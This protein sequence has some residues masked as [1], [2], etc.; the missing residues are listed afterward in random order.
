MF[1]AL[2]LHVY[3]A[4]FPVNSFTPFF[5]IHKCFLEMLSE[6]QVEIIFK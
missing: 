1:L 3:L 5:I 4:G 6:L 2:E